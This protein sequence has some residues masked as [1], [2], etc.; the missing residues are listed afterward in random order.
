MKAAKRGRKQ[1]PDHT[2]LRRY[3]ILFLA[4]VNLFIVQFL[5]VRTLPAILVGTE[6]ILFLV[7]FSYFLGISAGYYVSDRLSERGLRLLALAQFA[8]HL[9][10]PFSL[11]FISAFLMRYHLSLTELVVMLGLGAIRGRRRMMRL[12]A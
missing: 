6:V 3:A 8:T 4:G 10:L 5:A 7:V 2:P 11:R 12:A 1:S 9:T